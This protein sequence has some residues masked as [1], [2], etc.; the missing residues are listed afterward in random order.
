MK[1]FLIPILIV[2][3]VAGSWAAPA[4]QNAP[5]PD[6]SKVLGTWNIEINADG[7][8]FYLTLV[9]EAVE[10]RLAGKVS[11]ENG[12]FTDAALSD[13]AYE[14]EILKCTVT[15]PSPP[16]MATRPWAIEL[17]VGP[18]TLE[19]TI[20]NAELMISATMTGKRTKK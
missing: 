6:L 14:G 15:V 9:M 13:I 4:V 12:M 19:G 17:K 20:G 1:R 2:G 5:K 3:L 10:G 11:E 16:D 7:Q 8:L 18:D